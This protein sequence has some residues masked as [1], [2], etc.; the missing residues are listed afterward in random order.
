[1][2]VYTR[3]SIVDSASAI[4]SFDDVV[5]KGIGFLN[6]FYSDLVLGLVWPGSMMAYVIVASRQSR[7]AHDSGA[8][9]TWHWAN[10]ANTD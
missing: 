6:V 2:Y 9:L 10:Q 8:R 1:M 3:G 4:Q 7:T 5:S